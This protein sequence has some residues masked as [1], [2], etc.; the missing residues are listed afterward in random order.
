MG[1][2][3]TLADVARSAG[4][5][6]STVSS[7]LNGRGSA[8]RISDATA[9]R[10]RAAANG[11]GYRPDPAARSL[12]TGR[13]GTVGF[14]SDEVTVTRY[15]SA[16]IRGILDTA[17]RQGDAVLIAET[18][19]DRDRVGRSIRN[20]R[21]RRTDG[22]LYGLMRARHI[23]VPPELGAMPCVI[24][25]GSADAV[26]GVLP[27]EEAAGR[28][29]MRHL[30][31]SGH[32]RIALIGRSPLHLD[33]EFS[34]TIGR[35]LEGVD[36]AMR[37]AGLRFEY[38]IAGA[39]WE[40]DLGYTGGLEILEEAPQTTAVLAAND[41]VAFGVYQAAQQRGL[42]IPEDLSVMSFD[43]EYLAGYL[44]PGLTTMRLPYREMGEIALDLL[45]HRI[46]DDGN[47]AT[48]DPPTLVP[49]PLVQRDSV[50]R[51]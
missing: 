15:A 35:R 17:E 24:V 23:E 5:A 39:Q 38:E 6:P 34:A 21:A 47:R 49:M 11:L 7:V 22:L 25:N 30:L 46:R 31:D 19:E 10:V 32:R 13:T 45:R 2:R 28:E 1:D 43:D 4:V 40:P 48:T 20:L 3:V 29:A 14:L 27:D 33:P 36:E 12:R 44:R 26:P 50:R 37:T 16:M 9:E 42:R 51:L 41:R 18:G 8:A